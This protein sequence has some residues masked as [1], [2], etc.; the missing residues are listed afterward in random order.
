MALMP[1]RAFH[2]QICSF[3]SQRQRLRVSSVLS[4]VSSAVE[5]FTYTDLR[6]TVCVCV[7]GG[8]GGRTKG[9]GLCTDFPVLVRLVRMGWWWGG[10]IQGEKSARRC[11]IALNWY[12]TWFGLC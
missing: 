2:D 9:R 11:G 6:I 12:P 5:S 4:I 10:G 7:G 8:G 3:I 1:N